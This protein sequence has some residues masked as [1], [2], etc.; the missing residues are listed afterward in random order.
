MNF[1]P[2]KVKERRL[3]LP[4]GELQL[5]ERFKQLPASRLIAGIRPE[6]FNYAESVAGG[7]NMLIFRSTIDVVEWLGAELFVYSDINLPKAA[8][9]NINEMFSK[10]YL[11]LVCRL[12]PSTPVRKGESL[13]LQLN[14]RDIDLFDGETGRNLAFPNVER[15][16]ETNR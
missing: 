3:V 11:T 12:D 8:R 14:A 7:A 2:A 5:P 16:K 10:G 13:R 1:V 6:A 15:D 9:A 4:F